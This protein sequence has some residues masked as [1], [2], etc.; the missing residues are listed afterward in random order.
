MFLQSTLKWWRN[1]KKI[2]KDFFKSSIHPITSPVIRPESALFFVQNL[3]REKSA[4]ERRVNFVFRPILH[5]Q[6]GSLQSSIWKT[7]KGWKGF[8]VKPWKPFCHQLS[9]Q[10]TA[11]TN[12]VCLTGRR[13]PRF[14]HETNAFFIG[15]RSFWKEAQI[16]REFPSHNLINKLSQSRKVSAETEKTRGHSIGR[17]GSIFVG[18]LLLHW[19]L[20]YLHDML[21][22]SLLIQGAT[23]KHELHRSH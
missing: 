20:P 14:Y 11:W 4:L 10:L 17:A 7:L 22:R 12:G 2:F 1:K 21:R 3:E 15:K 18:K 9:P 19:C 23:K 13:C 5:I 8:S 6:R 16:H